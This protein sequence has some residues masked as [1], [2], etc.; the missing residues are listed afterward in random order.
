MKQWHKEMRERFPE[1]YYVWQY[2]R[3]KKVGRGD[4]NKLE[5][6]ILVRNKLEKK[7]R[8]FLILNG[9]K[10]EY[11]PYINVSGKAYFPDFKIGN[12]IIEATEWKHPDKDKI[13]K[14]NKKIK[15]YRKQ[16]FEVVLYI[17]EIFRKFY[18]EIECSIISELAPLK[19]FLNA[20][21]A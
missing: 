6:K 1:E 3:F 2:E 21:V 4:S 13:M 12:K 10:F 16:G 14:L 5:N 15:D 9:F 17:P 19:A 20:P 11:E 8:D 7:M 18:K